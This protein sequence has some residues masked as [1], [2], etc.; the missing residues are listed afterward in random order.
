MGERERDEA[1]DC[2][3]AGGEREREREFGVWMRMGAKAKTSR[4]RGALIRERGRRG[5]DR[6]ARGG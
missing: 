6:D 4:G 1:L 2:D 3:D 5:L